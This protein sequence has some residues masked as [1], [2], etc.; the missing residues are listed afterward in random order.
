MPPAPRVL[1]LHGIWMPGASMRPLARA[2]RA[3]GFDT[4]IFAYAAVRGGPEAT[5]PALRARLLRCDHVVGHS[6]GGLMAL[7]ALRDLPQATVQRVV[8]LGSPLAG[9]AAASALAQRRATAWAVG[10]SGELLQRGLG[11]WS[12][13][14]QVG[15]LAGQRPYGMGRLFARFPGANDGSVA[16]EETCLP[17]IAD[18]RV[19]DATHTSLLVSPQAAALAA[20]F[21]R[22]GRF[23][24]A[25][26]VS[27]IR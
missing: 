10:R 26:E 20:H 9:S 3:A 11:R 27:A 21:L 25:D 19:L 13:T 1:L 15:V 14:A 8:C 12:G 17:G 6:L 18:H 4:E 7:G 2:L 22:H 24:A 23:G 16:V 5:W